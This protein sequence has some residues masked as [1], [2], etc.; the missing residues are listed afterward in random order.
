MQQSPTHQQVRQ[1]WAAALI[2]PEE[3]VAANACKQDARSSISHGFRNG[4]V[5]ARS[6]A[7]CVG[8]A[9]EAGVPES[10]SGSL[11]ALRNVNPILPSCSFRKSD[12]VSF[13]ACGGCFERDGH[14]REIP[15][16]AAH[17]PQSLVGQQNQSCRIK[18]ATQFA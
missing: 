2:G 5:S 17:L 7:M 18:S 1:F 12:E 11:N 14:S 8:R 6:E 10:E 15:D 3:V 13:V 9:R 16:V 4:S